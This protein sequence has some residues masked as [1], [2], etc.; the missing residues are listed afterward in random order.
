MDTFI[1]DVQR[2]EIELKQGDFKKRKVEILQ[3]FKSILPDDYKS[4]H[5]FISDFSVAFLD[6]YRENASILLDS[7]KSA[8]HENLTECYQHSEEQHL[9]SLTVEDDLSIHSI[10][11]PKSKTQS[12]WELNYEMDLDD[13]VFHLYFEGWKFKTIGHTL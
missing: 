10:N 4:G 8:L 1:L 3:E 9:G 6:L 7:Y 5:K 12:E 2:R 11:F 13:T